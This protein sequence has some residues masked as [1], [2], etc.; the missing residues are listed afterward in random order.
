MMTHTPSLTGAVSKSLF[1]LLSSDA[2]NVLSFG[3]DPTGVSDSSAAINAAL[4]SG[5]KRIFLPEGTYLVDGLVFPAGGG[6]TMFGVNKTS[7]KI[8]KNGNGT[9]SLYRA[10][11]ANFAACIWMAT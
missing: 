9:S 8:K 5:K 11:I 7:T 1:D 4:A 3:A 6:V 2:V 10:A